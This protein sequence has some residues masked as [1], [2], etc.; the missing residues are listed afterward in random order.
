M[1]DHSHARVRG[2]K[3]RLS[4]NIAL[5][6]LPLPSCL[7]TGYSISAKA[8]QH[9]IEAGTPLSDVA[10]SRSCDPASTRDGRQHPQSGE[11]QFLSAPSGVGLTGP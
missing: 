5:L 4:K 2:A 9:L 6:K 7:T 8:E 1:R 3:I 10:D 11:P